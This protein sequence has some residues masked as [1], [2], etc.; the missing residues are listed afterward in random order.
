MDTLI[1][2]LIFKRFRANKKKYKV[3]LR[4][5]KNFIKHFFLLGLQSQNFYVK[6]RRIF[7]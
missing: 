6:R 7:R 4:A 3:I 2:K 5:L 1:K